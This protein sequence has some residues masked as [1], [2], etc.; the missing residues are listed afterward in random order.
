MKAQLEIF[1][2]CSLAK[3][4]WKNKKNYDLREHLKIRFIFDPSKVYIY[5]L[6]KVFK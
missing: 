2:T 1:K 6:V 4:T 3:K 5:H